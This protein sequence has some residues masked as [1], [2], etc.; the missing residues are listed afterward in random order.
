MGHDGY[1][2]VDRDNHSDLAIGDSTSN[3]SEA[4]TRPCK[5]FPSKY[6]FIHRLVYQVNHILSLPFSCY[7]RPLFQQLRPKFR[8]Y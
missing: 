3:H 8:T 1:H 6:A 5:D 7:V 4:Q 2:L